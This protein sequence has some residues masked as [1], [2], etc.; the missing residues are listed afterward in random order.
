MGDPGAE[1]EHRRV[2]RGPAGRGGDHAQARVLDLER[3]DGVAGVAT[4]DLLLHRREEIGD[5]ALEELERE[6]CQARIAF[7]NLDARL[8]DQRRQLRFAPRRGRCLLDASARRHPH[9]ETASE[10]RDRLAEIARRELAAAGAGRPSR[11]GFVRSAIG[12]RRLAVAAL[13]SPAA[14]TRGQCH[15]QRDAGAG[16]PPHPD[17]SGTA[18][19]IISTI[20]RSISSM[21]KGLRRNRV[22]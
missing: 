16:V 21:S 15:D 9:L 5:A 12:P 2:A 17:G 22:R 20:W 1:D 7:A 10:Q 13:R 11:T 19:A 6:Q 4:R 18:P 3:L 8:L 14:T